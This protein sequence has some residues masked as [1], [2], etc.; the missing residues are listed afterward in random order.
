MGI[1]TLKPTV[2]R[3]PIVFPRVEYTTTAVASS[4]IHYKDH[5][6]PKGTYD[7]IVTAQMVGP[8]SSDGSPAWLWFHSLETGKPIMSLLAGQTETASTGPFTLVEDATFVL[9][10]KDTASYLPTAVT[11]YP[12][13]VPYSFEGRTSV[14]TS[15]ATSTTTTFSVTADVTTN[16][17]YMGVGYDYDNNTVCYIQPTSSALV[18]STTAYAVGAVKIHRLAAGATT[19]TKTNIT[20]NTTNSWYSSLTGT[21]GPGYV[22][23]PNDPQN[24][25][26]TYFF[27]KNNELHVLSSNAIYNDGTTMSGW[28]KVNCATAGTKTWSLGNSDAA[29]NSPTAT[30]FT[31][32]A[33]GQTRMYNYTH[34]TLSHKVICLGYYNTNSYAT[35]WTAY[36]S[37]WDIATNTNDY[38][39]S[40]GNRNM[41]LA[42][43]ASNTYGI[44]L[45]CFYPSA[46]LGY[47]YAYGKATNSTP[48]LLNRSGTIYVSNAVPTKVYSNNTATVVNY[49]G[50]VSQTNQPTHLNF[51]TPGGLFMGK[52]TTSGN[53]FISPDITSTAN[54]SSTTLGACN[55]TFTGN[56]YSTNKYATKAW[57]SP[58]GIAITGSGSS[59]TGSS[60]RWG[61][62]LVGSKLYL[63]HAAQTYTIQGTTVYQANIIFH[64]YSMPATENNIMRYATTMMA[65][66]AT[67]TFGL[68]SFN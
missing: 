67:P 7:F 48:A 12:V 37:Q 25:V 22:V 41:Y 18:T 63:I 13:D 14:L 27:I 19:Y 46:S 21:A 28:A 10:G 43:A 50:G 26:T 5:V 33:G 56:S 58:A 15:A 65:G 40:H 20:F 47:A 42:G 11:F 54:T 53:F 30:T 34:D 3:Q 2:N 57:G 29:F 60:N 8:A 55:Y 51:I 4:L 59:G 61:Y 24:Y 44:A 64:T 62:Y 52:T 66:Y 38:T 17:S 35:A 9:Y 1:T 36:W 23:Y 39:T 32:D 49:L 31:S 16:F 45:D 6:L 68:N